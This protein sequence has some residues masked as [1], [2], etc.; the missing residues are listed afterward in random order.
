MIDNLKN[1]TLG[2]SD[3]ES[4]FHIAPLDRVKV[5]P[6]LDGHVFLAPHIGQ[7]DIDARTDV[8]AIRIW[9]KA[10]E[11]GSSTFRCYQLAAERIINWAASERRKPLSAFNDADIV[12]FDEFLA[13]PR[14]RSR[15]ISPRGT[16]RSDPAWTPFVGRLSPRSRSVTLSIILAML[17]WLEDTFNLGVCRSLRPHA[18]RWHH[19]P[20]SLRSSVTQD[21]PPTKIIGIDDWRLLRHELSN[22]TPQDLQTRLAIELMYYGGLTITEV[23]NVRIDHV[24][25]TQSA[26]LLSIPS[27]SP[28]VSTIYLLPPVTM[29]IDKLEIVTPTSAR[30]FAGAGATFSDEGRNPSHLVSTSTRT[31]RRQIKGAFHHAG[32]V[33]LASGGKSAASRLES[34]TAHSLCQAFELHAREFDDAN[35]IWFL[36]GAARFVPAVTRQYLPP[37]KE[38]SKL[39]LKSAIRSLSPC[40]LE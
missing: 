23:S 32:Q 29:T 16:A 12:A 17:D 37:R 5:P 35:W 38:L 10:Y 11:N 34:L 40:W 28:E 7:G 8:E 18:R 26:T 22:D 13:N 2:D 24:I 30:A 31:I 27:R 14:P 19:R 39:E 6:D 15:W 33:A 20:S 1:P 36:T 21:S 9:L 3:H 4:E 25:R